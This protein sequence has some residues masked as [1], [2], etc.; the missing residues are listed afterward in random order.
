MTKS[1]KELK[2]ENSFLK[3]KTEKSDFTL[4][5]LVEEVSVDFYLVT[6]LF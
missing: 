2:K 5:Q 3:G 6:N 4:V 1:I